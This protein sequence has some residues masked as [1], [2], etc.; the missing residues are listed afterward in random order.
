MQKTDYSIIVNE[1]SDGRGDGKKIIIT[2]K[3]KEKIIK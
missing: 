2:P 1:R 3:E